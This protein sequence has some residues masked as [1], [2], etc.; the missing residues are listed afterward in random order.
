M[1]VAEKK[2]IGSLTLEDL[3]QSDIIRE[4]PRIEHRAAVEHVKTKSKENPI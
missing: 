1:L 4:D 2:K 3:E